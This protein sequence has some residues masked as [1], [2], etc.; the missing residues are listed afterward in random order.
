M[1]DLRPDPPATRARQRRP[2]ALAPPKPAPSATIEAVK[3]T[4][5]TPTRKVVPIAEAASRRQKKRARESWAGAMASVPDDPDEAENFTM[6][7]NIAL[8]EGH[9]EDAVLAFSRALAIAPHAVSARAGRGRA[10]ALLGQH[11]LALADL[12]IAL[13]KARTAALH[14]VRAASLAAL[15]LLVDAVKATSRALRV[16]PKCAQAY[17]L[18]AIFGSHVDAEDPQVTSD[19]GRAAELAPNV[20]LYSREH[21]KRLMGM[22]EYDLA[23]ADLDKAL[24]VSPDD[25]TLLHMHGVCLKE[26]AVNAP[27]GRQVV[28]GSRWF[29]EDRIRANEAA[30][31]SLERALVLAPKQGELF[32]AIVYSIVQAREGMPDEAAYLAA[33]DRGVAETTNE[34]VYLSV[35]EGV[36]RR[37]GDIAG[38]DVDKARMKELGID[39]E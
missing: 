19:L 16:D 29:D 32:E 33:L 23:L 11:E 18:R 34:C 28:V 6:L 10:R 24:S 4:P 21:A 39:R 13:R 3:K 31:V 1:R 25:P 17:Y 8:I 2:V 37:R 35:R 9:H 27:S 30:L 15:G 26:R 36:R 22:E 12:D 20:V 14:L 38:A 7:G 5:P